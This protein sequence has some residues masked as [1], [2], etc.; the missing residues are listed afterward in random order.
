MKR[1]RPLDDLREME[2]KARVAV[3]SRCIASAAAVGFRKPPARETGTRVV[4]LAFGA[5]AAAA[6]AVVVAA[7]DCAFAGLRLHVL[8]V[9]AGAA[10]FAGVAAVA[11]VLDGPAA[12]VP[13]KVKDWFASP[14]LH[15]A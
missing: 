9:D 10:A 13:P 8:G 4:G 6:A 12:T 15:A 11:A 5:W 3:G 2:L 1:Q 14:A 7:A